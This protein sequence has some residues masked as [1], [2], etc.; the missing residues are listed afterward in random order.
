MRALQKIKGK[1]PRRTKKAL[2]KKVQPHI[3]RLLKEWNEWEDIPGVVIDFP[4]GASQPDW[5]YIFVSPRNGYWKGGTFQFEFKVP[6]EYP[7]DPPVVNCLTTPIYHPNIDTNGNICL[8]ILRPD[9]L[10]TNTFENIVYGLILLFENP[11]F[12]DPLPSRRFLPEMEPFE[13][14][15]RDQEK[16]EKIV[17]KTMQ[18]GMIE[19]VGGLV[20]ADVMSS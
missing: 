13:L 3:V 5:F 12:I 8:N 1:E 14:W 6:T 20:F 19:E 2:K 10:P 18:G 9:W 11:N 15:R 16:F 17:F 4:K 7:I